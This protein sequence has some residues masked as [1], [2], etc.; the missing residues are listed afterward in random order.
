MLRTDVGKGLSMTWSAPGASRLMR[1][2]S[3]T[4]KR[5]V[6]L[7]VSPI[8]LTSRCSSGI[9]VAPVSDITET[10]CRKHGVKAPSA[11]VMEMDGEKGVNGGGSRKTFLRCFRVGTGR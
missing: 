9:P 7:P 11:L 5:T 6:L 2:T 4:P 8:D 1:S 10:P 3:L